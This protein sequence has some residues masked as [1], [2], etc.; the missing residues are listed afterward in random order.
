MSIVSI[1]TYDLMSASLMYHSRY[2]FE[3]KDLYIERASLDTSRSRIIEIFIGR[4]RKYDGAADCP[5]VVPYREQR[6]RAL[7]A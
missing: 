2:A 7:I 1:V 6:L 5:V 3:Q 4:I